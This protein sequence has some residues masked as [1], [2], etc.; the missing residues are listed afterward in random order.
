MSR[1]NTA[2]GPRSPGEDVEA[3]RQ[4]PLPPEQAWAAVARCIGSTVGLLTRRHIHQPRT[5]V[6]R[7]VRF[8]DG[9]AAGST[10]R[11]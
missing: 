8:A 9:T 1:H 6:G 10:A 11:P 2:V 7:L 4:R 5:H 3:A